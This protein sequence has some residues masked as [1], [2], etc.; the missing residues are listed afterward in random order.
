MRNLFF[1][2]ADTQVVTERKSLVI[3]QGGNVLG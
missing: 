1:L 2:D 3:S